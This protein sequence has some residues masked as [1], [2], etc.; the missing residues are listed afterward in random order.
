MT[1]LNTVRAASCA[2]VVPTRNRA[3]VI[4]ETLKCIALLTVPREWDAQL[5]V[6]DNGSTDET[7]S[8]T[9]LMELGG[10]P[11][12]MIRVQEPGVARARNRGA[13][14]ATGAVILFLDDDVRPPTNWLVDMASPILAGNVAATAG[15]FRI[16]E[17]VWQ[18]WMTD[19]ERGMLVSEHSIDPGHPFLASGNMAVRRELF[20]RLGG[21]EEEL[22]PGALGAG[23]E[24]LL[25]T[26]RLQDAGE[27]IVAV[28]SATANHFVD[29]SKLTPEA[30]VDR[31]AEAARS[32]AW[33]AHHWWG[34]QDRHAWLKWCLFRALAVLFPGSR[35]LAASRSW[36][37][38]MRIEQRRSPKYARKRGDIPT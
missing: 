37:G 6:V 35:R 38:Q 29:V 23:G 8:L 17:E 24:D 1:R 34:R 13:A 19:E 16:D 33:I 15:L 32:E 7:P 9:H 22:G 18:P 12:Q 36:H 2:L 28:K 26:W 25:L 10:R 21:F 5:V 3:G 30:L 4:R 11:G 20:D 31:A 14:A 27:Q